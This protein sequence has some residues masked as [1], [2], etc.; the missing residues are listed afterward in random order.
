MKEQFATYE[1][2]IKLKELGFDEPCLGRFDICNTEELKEMYEVKY[3]FT[4]IN[5]Y[6][7]SECKTINA[8]LWQ[9]VQS[10]LDSKGVII[11]IIFV[12]NVFKYTLNIENYVSDEFKDRM[13][14]IKNATEYAVGYLWNQKFNK[15]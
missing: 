12:D 5:N 11:G 4:P 15:Q 6:F 3:F 7:N 13:S 2:S 8:P 9:Q 10:F 1:I 14:A